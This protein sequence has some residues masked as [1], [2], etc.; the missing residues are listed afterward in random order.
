MRYIIIFLMLFAAVLPAQMNFLPLK[1]DKATFLGPEGRSYL[2]VYLSFYQKD[3][4]YQIAEDH[5]EAAYYALVEVMSGDS[6]IARDAKQRADMVN[7][8]QA[9]KSNRQF[10]NTFIFDLPPGKYDFKVVVRDVNSKRFGEFVDEVNIPDYS[11]PGLQLSDIQLGNLIKKSNEQ[12]EFDKNTFRIIPNPDGI[13][14]PGQ[15]ILYYYM[16]IYNLV[17][18]DTEKYTVESW[19][20][21]LSGD[22]IRSFPTQKKA[23][24]GASAVWVSGINILSTESGQYAL[25]VKVTDPESGQTAESVK[26]LRIYRPGDAAASQIV[27][28]PHQQNPM[29]NE[30]YASM[31]EEQLDEEF[32]YARYIATKQEKNVYKTLDLNAKRKF[33]ADFWAKR[34]TDPSTDINEFKRDYF[35]RVEYANRYFTVGQA[36]GWKSD[37]GRVL[38]QYGKPDEVERHES[39]MDMMPFVIWSYHQLEGGVDFIF[40]DANGM[41]DMLLLHSTYSKEVYN[42][43]WPRLLKR[44]RGGSSGQGGF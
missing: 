12:T 24:P 15:P 31:T 33:L 6:V 19:L 26:T 11:R 5:F 1:V 22:T 18:S 4:T 35:D 25:H 28:A 43:D 40:G 20:T 2:E 8:N 9:L 32:E 37:R 38:L 16:E 7:D 23:K 39:E 44:A 41:G 42:P 30:I 17:P 21:N 14:H 29:I 27:K 36:P 3:L 34:D 13:F 10:V